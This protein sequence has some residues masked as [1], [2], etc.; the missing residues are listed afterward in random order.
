MTW[1]RIPTTTRATRSSTASTG[2]RGSCAASTHHP[3]IR[4]S[5]PQY[6]AAAALTARP[7]SAR[8]RCIPV[9][10]AAR[11]HRSRCAAGRRA[12]PARPGRAPGQ[13]HDPRAEER[14]LVGAV[15]DEHRRAARLRADLTDV[16]LQPLPGQRVQ[17]RER[18]VEQEQRRLGGQCPRDRDPLLL[19]AADLPDLAVGGAL[20]ADALAAAGPAARC[21]AHAAPWR[22]S[23]PGRRCRRR[24]ATGTAA[25]AGTPRPPSRPGV[26]GV[27]GHRHRAL[28]RRLEAGDQPQ[29]RALAAARR[30]DQHQERP[31]ST[32]RSTGPSAV[33]SLRPWP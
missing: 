27:A 2:W 17:R 3:P 6:Y 30:A 4:R 23:A 1:I 16:L 33:T 25:A 21:G 28:A 29:Q 10:A 9:S 32:S 20:E 13:H 7:T 22:T 19:T 12:G 8:S 11:R 5:K 26:G 15:G 31:G 14:C 18:L 24:C